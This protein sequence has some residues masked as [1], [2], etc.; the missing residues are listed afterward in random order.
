MNQPDE[1]KAIIQDN[2]PISLKRRIVAAANSQG[3]P[4]IQWRIRAYEEKLAREHD[5]E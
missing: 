1:G 3:I 2:V 4:G 5:R